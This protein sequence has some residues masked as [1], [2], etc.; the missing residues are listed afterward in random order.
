MFYIEREYSEVLGCCLSLKLGQIALHIINY[1]PCTA[2]F[3]NSVVQ[4]IMVSVK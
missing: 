4:L 3:G 2:C 1:K